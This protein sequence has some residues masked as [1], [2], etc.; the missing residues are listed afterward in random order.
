M[1][2]TLMYSELL[3]DIQ[4]KNRTEV[5]GIPETAARYRA[6]AGKEKEDE[7]KRC[8][9]DAFASLTLT[10]MRFLR[11]EVVPMDNEPEVPSFFEIDIIGSERRLGGKMTAIADVMHSMLVNMT[12]S[13]FYLG[14]GQSDLAQVRDS[15]AAAD[16]NSLKRLIYSKQPPILI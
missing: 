4:S 3:Y 10:C 13:R 2:I 7:I 12:L 6:E 16:V 9:L 14:V 15:L 5:M 8:M 11:G 1:K